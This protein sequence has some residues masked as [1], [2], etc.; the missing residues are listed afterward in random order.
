[1]NSRIR[2]IWKSVYS[3]E[4]ELYLVAD[5]S[6]AIGKAIQSFADTRCRTM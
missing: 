6:Q 1:M 3:M 4:M 2:R 5:K